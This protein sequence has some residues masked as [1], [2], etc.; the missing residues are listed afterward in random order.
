MKSKLKIVLVMAALVILASCKKDKQAPITNK[1]APAANAGVDQAFSV[2]PD[3][4]ILDGSASTDADGNIAS[5]QWTRISGP[6]TM[7]IVNGSSAVTAVKEMYSARLQGGVYEFELTVRDNDGL[8]STDRVTIIID[9]KPVSVSVLEYGSNEPIEGAIIYLARTPNFYGPYTWNDVIIT[10]D[11]NGQASFAAE[12]FIFGGTSKSEYWDYGME[13]FHGDDPSMAAQNIHTADSVT[14]WKIPQTTVTVHVQN[15]IATLTDHVF[16]NQWGTTTPGYINSAV[17]LRP[18]IDTTFEL[19]VC[20]NM[21]NSFLV[22]GEPDGYGN[23]GYLLY[24]GNQFVAKN[25]NL[26]MNIV[27]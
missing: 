13:T 16:L 7:E 26:V 8:V 6:V 27:Y 4:I 2:A 1:N 20:G 14:I 11:I 10:S 5:Y 12:R 17:C 23:F 9:E 3:S 21:L 24:Q 25:S 19:L 18:N 22:G 15:T